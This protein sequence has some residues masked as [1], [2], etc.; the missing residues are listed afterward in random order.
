VLYC[1]CVINTVLDEYGV[2]TLFV[3]ALRIFESVYI[4]YTFRYTLI[5]RKTYNFIDNPV[6]PFIKLLKQCSYLP[7]TT[8]EVYAIARDVC[9]SVCLS[10]SVQYYSK[11]VH[12]F[13]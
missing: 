1:Y 11:R 3:R 6:D 5:C 10:V 2:I 7:P 4:D 8:E 13:G 9:L 12:G